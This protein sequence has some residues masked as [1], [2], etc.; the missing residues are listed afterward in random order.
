MKGVQQI[1]YT[2]CLICC[3]RKRPPLS[4][5]GLIVWRERRDLSLQ[6]DCSVLR[7]LLS[8]AGTGFEPVPEG[9]EPPVVA[10]L[11]YPAMLPRCLRAT[12]PDPFGGRRLNPPSCA[13][14]KVS[15]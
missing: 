15:G 9:Y 13:Y 1:Q 14:L 7:L 2:P 10:R 4:P 5:G 11:Y 6:T 3:A 12:R 8:S